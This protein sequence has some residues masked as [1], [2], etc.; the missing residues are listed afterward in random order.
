MRRILCE[1]R[2]KPALLHPRKYAVG[3]A[4]LIGFALAPKL[5]LPTGLLSSTA[6]TVQTKESPLQVKEAHEL[7][8]SRKTGKKRLTEP[9]K[10]R[11]KEDRLLRT[12]APKTEKSSTYQ[13]WQKM[14]VQLLLP[15]KKPYLSWNSCQYFFRSATPS[16]EHCSSEI[17]KLAKRKMSLNRRWT[18]VLLSRPTQRSINK[19]QFILTSIL[20]GNDGMRLCWTTWRHSQW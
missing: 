11:S 14:L 4:V 20:V 2:K 5:Y 18:Q 13:L 12:V 7:Q 3:A 8:G 10:R 19:I 6:E 17:R 1:T 15:R 16:T 9:V